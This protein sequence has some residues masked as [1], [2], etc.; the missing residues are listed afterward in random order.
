VVASASPARNRIEIACASPGSAL[1]AICAATSTGAAPAARSTSAALALERAPGRHRDALTD[2]L[3]GDV[4]PEGEAVATLDEQPGVDELLHRSEQRR[5]GSVEHVGQV[6][7]GETGGRARRR[8]WRPRERARRPAQALAHREADAAG[9][10]R[11]DQFCLTGDDADQVLV[12]EAGQQLHE[13]ER[14]AARALD[15]IEE[16]DVG[17]GVR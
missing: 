10:A 9:Q 16:R 17:L 5:R 1:A 6:G 14:A 2:R 13:H 11:L 12:P 15:Q 8:P 7:E 4:V 3:A